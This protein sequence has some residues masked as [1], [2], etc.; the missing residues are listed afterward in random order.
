MYNKRSIANFENLPEILSAEETQSII[1][2]MQFGDR[3]AVNILIEHNIKLVVYR[4]KSKFSGTDCEAEELVSVGMYAL[5]KAANAYDPS[6]GASFSTFA[7]KCIDNEILKFL[8]NFRNKRE[9]DISLEAPV[10]DKINDSDSKLIDTIEDDIDWFSECENK[11]I[12]DFINKALLDIP[13]RN[14]KMVMLYFG[15]IDGKMY[16]Q[17]EIAK[18]LDV[19]YALVSKVIINELDRIERKLVRQGFIERHVKRKIPKRSN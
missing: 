19:S 17:R 2:R 4:V 1:K 11:E 15:F 10:G 12:Y 18:M 9:K 5:V 16:S 14:R 6:K 3:E 7:V 8:K 13:P